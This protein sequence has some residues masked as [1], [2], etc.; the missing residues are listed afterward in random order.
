M[1]GTELPSRSHPQDFR[2]YSLTTVQLVAYDFFSAGKALI[3]TENSTLDS[4]PL[5]LVCAYAMCE[6]ME[7]QST[8]AS[9]DLFVSL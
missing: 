2:S 6:A 3:F 5:R 7:I 1:E 8:Q 9:S 4:F